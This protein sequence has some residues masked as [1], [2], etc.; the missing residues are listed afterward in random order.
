[1]L[2]FPAAHYVLQLMGA[3]SKSTI[4][5]FAKGAGKNL[6]FYSYRSQ[7]RGKPWFIVVTGPYADKR[8]AQAAQAELPEAVRNQQPW[9]RTLANVQADIRAHR[10]TR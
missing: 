4:D 3:E 7:L 9:P 8:A 1:M 2:S 5:K 6:K 10:T